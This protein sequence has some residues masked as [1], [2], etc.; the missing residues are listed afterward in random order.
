MLSFVF[1]LAI[2]SFSLE[3]MIASKFPAM[4]KIASNNNLANLAISISLSYLIGIMFGAAGLIAMT[5]GIVSTLMSIPGYAVLY[6][7]YDSE[8]A[9]QR[10]GNQI[11]YYKQKTKDSRDKWTILAKDIAKMTYTTGKIVTAPIWITRNIY[12]K[13]KNLKSNYITNNKSSN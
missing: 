6:N 9:Q 7:I 4:R 3:M 11:E 13:G 2:A 8:K 5:A 12:L 1:V 10:G